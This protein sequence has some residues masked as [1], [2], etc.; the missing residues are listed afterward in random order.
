MKEP[1]S[2]PNFIAAVILMEDSE[3]CKLFTGKTS[4]NRVVKQ[5]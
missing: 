1:V 4:E 5:G 3:F 2:L